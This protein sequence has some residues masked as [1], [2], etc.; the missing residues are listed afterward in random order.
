MT[1]CPRVNCKNEAE[2]SSVFGILP[3]ASCQRKD[4]I[5]S[6]GL[7]PEFYSLN[8]MHRV[9]GDRDQHGKDHL[10]PYDGNKANPE[11]FRAYPEKI[12]EYGVEGELSKL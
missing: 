3:C 12:Q 8:K 9:Q 1:K 4:E 10:Q 11:F 7:S 6:A 5:Y 2:V